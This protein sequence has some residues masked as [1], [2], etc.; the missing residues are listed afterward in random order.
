MYVS[1][2]TKDRIKAF[3]KKKGFVISKMLEE[4]GLNTNTLNQISEE[5]GL[6]S[7]SLAKIADYLDC[8][9][10]YLLCRTENPDSHKTHASDITAASDDKQL[11][12]II[13]IYRQLDDIG[14]AKLLVT[15]DEILNK[16]SV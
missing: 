7:F 14:K 3:V 2:T 12:I 6:S 8:S 11:A 16:R 15:A 5:R 4:C 13:G 10:D 9:V 1:Q